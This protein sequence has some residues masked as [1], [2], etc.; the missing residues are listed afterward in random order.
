MLP[1]AGAELLARHRE[2]CHFSTEQ[3]RAAMQSPVEHDAGADA[4]AERDE[5]VVCEALRGAEPTLAHRRG[6][7]IVFECDRHAASLTHQLPDRYVVPARHV[8]DRCDRSGSGLNSAGQRD[9]DGRD[10]VANPDAAYQ[11]VDRPAD[12]IEHILR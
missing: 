8:C 11:L 10:P 2:E 4:G 1:V 12:S 6:V 7:R 9:A 5:D 3:V